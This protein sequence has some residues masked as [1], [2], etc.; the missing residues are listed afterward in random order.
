MEQRDWEKTYRRY[1]GQ[2]S[3]CLITGVGLTEDGFPFLIVAPHG[4]TSDTAH[5][6]E[7]SQD[8]EGNGAGF[9]FIPDMNGGRDDSSC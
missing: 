8:P 5:R 7:I 9:L 6:V 1:Y 3:G 4:G 2:L